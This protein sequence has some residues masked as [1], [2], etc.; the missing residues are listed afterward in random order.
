MESKKP[1][2]PAIPSLSLQASPVKRARSERLAE[3]LFVQE[4]FTHDRQH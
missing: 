1:L 2:F 4:E 3:I